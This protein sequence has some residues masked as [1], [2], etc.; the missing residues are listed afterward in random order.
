[1]YFML[2]SKTFNKLNLFYIKFYI[3]VL[4]TYKVVKNNIRYVNLISQ[5]QMTNFYKKVCTTYMFINSVNIILVKPC[6]VF[7]AH[8]L[9]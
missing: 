6:H 8:T 3:I 7:V 1:M 5:I 4:L 9:D 2:F